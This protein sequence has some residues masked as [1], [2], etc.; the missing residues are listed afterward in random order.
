MFF[1]FEKNLIT[2]TFSPFLLPFLVVKGFAH[3]L[4]RTTSLN[5]LAQAAK[6]VW[7]NDQQVTQMLD[8]WLLVDFKNVHEQAMFACGCEEE[9]IIQGFFSFLFFF[10]KKTFY[11][12][13]F[14]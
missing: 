9:T 5:H 14:L 11:L 13:L 7:Q 2:I 8:D 3:V 6:A 12:F 10:F 1:F 4:K